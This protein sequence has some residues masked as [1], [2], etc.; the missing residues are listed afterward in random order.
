MRAEER[1]E[2]L[3]FGDLEFLRGL[4]TGGEPVL[5]I[6]VVPQVPGG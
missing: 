1:F 3:V 4:V 5:C 6:V 2:D